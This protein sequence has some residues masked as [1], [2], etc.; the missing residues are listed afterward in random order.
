M[1][2][3]KGVSG[4]IMRM[5]TRD[6]VPTDVAIK[7]ATLVALGTAVSTNNLYMMR[8]VIQSQL[9]RTTWEDYSDKRG[10]R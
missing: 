1:Q 10:R 2:T 4:K 7:A 9:G 6:R 3:I 8:D 5:F